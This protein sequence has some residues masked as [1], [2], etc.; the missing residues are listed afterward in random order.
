M[1]K[2][3]FVRDRIDDIELASA[4]EED[5]L[6]YKIEYGILLDFFFPV[7]QSVLEAML[8]ITLASR[9]SCPPC[10]MLTAVPP[11]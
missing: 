2:N 1:E 5:V 3:N 11:P 7:E 10:A 8:H 4:D 9:L 6:Q